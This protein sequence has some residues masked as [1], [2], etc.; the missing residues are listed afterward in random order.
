[1]PSRGCSSRVARLADEVPVIS[2]THPDALDRIEPAVDEIQ[3]RL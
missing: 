1:L 2:L 3:A